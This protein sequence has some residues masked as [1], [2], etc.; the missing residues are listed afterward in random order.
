MPRPLLFAMSVLLA[1]ACVHGTGHLPAG[2]PPEYEETPLPPALSSAAAT[3]APAAN[4]APTASA[5]S[6][7]PVH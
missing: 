1:A 6:S 3:S 5:T 2:P 4:S 7:T